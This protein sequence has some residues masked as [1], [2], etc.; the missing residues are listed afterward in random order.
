MKTPTPKRVTVPINV[1]VDKDD[2][3]VVDRYARFSGFTRST[4]VASIIRAWARCD[5]AASPMKG[6]Q[7]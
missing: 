7:S 2:L 3:A 1:R 5:A 6:K 4:A